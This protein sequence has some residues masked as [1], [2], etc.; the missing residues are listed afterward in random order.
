MPIFIHCLP[1]NANI[2]TLFIYTCQY[3]YIVY[4]Q[5]PI[6]IHCLS[7]NVY[8]HMFFMQCLSTY[9]F[10]CSVYLHMFLCSVYL[11][12]FLCSVYL[13]IHQYLIQCYI[14]CMYSVYEV[15]LVCLQVK[16][17][18]TCGHKVGML[19]QSLKEYI[20]PIHRETSDIHRL[21]P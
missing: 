19:K 4:L 10:L 8:L 1:T 20:T 7:T 15:L 3:L 21:H 13:Y 9:V 11:H 12:M 17:V 6:L 18:S 14:Q 5:M 16:R 2:Y